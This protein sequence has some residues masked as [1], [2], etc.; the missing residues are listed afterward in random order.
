MQPHNFLLGALA[1]GYN[2]VT[3]LTIPDVSEALEA[4]AASGFYPEHTIDMPVSLNLLHS[5]FQRI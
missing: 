3:A 5:K 2:F 4:R 1:V